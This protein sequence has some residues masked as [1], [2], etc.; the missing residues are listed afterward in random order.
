VALT[1]N[2]DTVKGTVPLELTEGLAHLSRLFLYCNADLVG[3][4]PSELGQLE[5]LEELLLYKTRLAGTI[6]NELGCLTMLNQLL[7]D[8]NGLMTGTMP[9]E[10][11]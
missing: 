6:P 11:C 7:L 8:T 10:I 5:F 9:N 2:H 3:T 4:L 1:L